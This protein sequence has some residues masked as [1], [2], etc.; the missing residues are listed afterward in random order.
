M[1]DNSRTEDGKGCKET[2]KPSSAQN[3]DPTTLFNV[4]IKTV[5]DK[6][7]AWGENREKNMYN[8]NQ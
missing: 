1:T 5:T 4:P 3:I 6:C 8:T 2:C 7:G